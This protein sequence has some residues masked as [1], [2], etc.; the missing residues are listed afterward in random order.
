MLFSSFINLGIDTSVFLT[1]ADATVSCATIILRKNA[2]VNRKS[3]KT[4]G[5]YFDA[6][7]I[8]ERQ[9]ASSFIF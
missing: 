5:I 1:V 2:D 9:E 3:R 8:F 7:K 4:G 6:V